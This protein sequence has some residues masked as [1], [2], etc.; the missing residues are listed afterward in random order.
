MAETI[1]SINEERLKNSSSLIQ[2]AE[3]DTKSLKKLL[4]QNNGS[5]R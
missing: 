4:C 5:L 1:E 3:M 2:S